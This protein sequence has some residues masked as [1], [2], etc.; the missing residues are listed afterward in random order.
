MRIHPILIALAG[1]SA[2]MVLDP[3]PG[4][5]GVALSPC[6]GFAQVR[7]WTVS[8]WATVAHCVS[9]NILHESSGV[10]IRRV[11]DLSDARVPEHAHDWPVLSIFVL[12]GYLN[13]T[14]F[15]RRVIDSP[16]AVFYR[17]GS[18][19]RNTALSAGFEQ[20]EI[21]FDP[22]WLGCTAIASTPVAH[23]I[24]GYAG[25]MARSLAHYC[26]GAIQAAGIRIAISQFIAT[27]RG[28]QERADAPWV[29]VVSQCLRQDASLKV[30]ELA[31]KVGRHP[32]WLG[33][34]FRQATGEGLPEAA[35]RFRVESASRLLR[36][37]DQSYASVAL[38][39]GFC[40][41]SH[42]NRSF[43]RVLGRLP[44]AVRQDQ[45]RCGRVPTSARPSA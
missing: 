10:I 25:S 3:A 11:V 4:M 1:E 44:T 13:Q 5:A 2:F 40:D 14:E 24:G 37:T 22:A 34:A 23:W 29:D 33:A 42:M 36:E 7:Y 39:A 20:I 16:S 38:E 31:K 35:A 26:S 12:G 27:V 18:A 9:M 17:A 28:A 45:Y 15:G 21:E 32:S 6:I 43:R 30:H 41:Q 19:H 8:R